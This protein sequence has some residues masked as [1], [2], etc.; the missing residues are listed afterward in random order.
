MRTL[1][2]TDLQMSKQKL[3]VSFWRGRSFLHLYYDVTRVCDILR[4]C[5]HSCPGKY[6]DLER[7]LI[8]EFTAAQRRGEIGRMREVAAV[9]LHFKVTWKR[10]LK[11]R[12][13]SV[14]VIACLKTS[15]LNVIVIFLDYQ[16]GN[17][18]VCLNRVMH[19]AWTSTSSSVRKWVLQVW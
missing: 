9:L 2:V 10:H 5:F 6:H 1:S 18:C 19:T 15:T 4:F 17:A 3:Q 16:G 12:W 7:Q 11:T 8:Q 14:W 13:L